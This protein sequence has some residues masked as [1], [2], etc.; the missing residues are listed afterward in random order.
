MQFTNRSRFAVNAMIDLGLRK[1][2][3]VALSAIAQRERISI[4]YL[5]KIFG[6]LLKQGLVISTRGPG[7]G[8]SLGRPASDITAADIVASV[9]GS[10][11]SIQCCN[12]KVCQKDARCMAHDLW[13]GLSNCMFDFLQSK[14]LQQLVD[15]QILLAGEGSFE[16][17]QSSKTGVYALSSL[18][19]TQIN[20]PNSVF[21]W[22]PDDMVAQS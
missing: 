8:Y 13:A 15:E 17:T 14:T 6:F 2:S 1:N 18:K 16:E 20:V 4:S 9:D 22:R 10:F 21:A 19:T 7:G 12:G 11:D 5:E 3:S